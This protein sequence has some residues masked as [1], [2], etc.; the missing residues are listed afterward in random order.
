MGCGLTKQSKN[1]SKAN[2]KVL[3]ALVLNPGLF[4]SKFRGKL[5][6]NYTEIRKLGSGAFAEVKLCKYL[7]TNK[8][9]AVKVI[10]KAGLHQQQID[11]DFMLKEISVLTSLD[12]PNI[13]KCYE[14]FED[15]WRFY[16]AM[17]YCAGGELFAK[18]VQM[19]K[20]NEMQAAEIMHQLLS[21]ICYC[22]E[23]LVIHR[24]LKP[25][26]ILLDEKNG[27]LR[28]KVADFGS[29]CFLD[30]NK[31]LSGCFGSAYYV[32]PE[33]LQ[34]EYN[35][36]CDIW[37]CG[38]IL[39]ILLTGKPPYPGN[40]SKL[41]LNLIRTNPLKVTSE[42]VPGVSAEALDL[43]Q[44]MLAIHPKGR[45]SAKDAVNHP[46]ISEN[47]ASRPV[48]LSGT[49]STLE[50][51]NSSSKLKDAVHI[52]L[53]THVLSYEE[54][55]I[56]TQTFQIIDSNSDGKISRDELLSKYLETME[57][58]KAKDTVEHIMKEIDTNMSGDIDYTEF[59]SA[60]MD[61]NK[62]LSKENLEDAFKLFDRDHSGTISAEELMD[63]LGQNA[64]LPKEI[65]NEV[66]READQNGDGVIDLR[67]FVNLMTN[68]FN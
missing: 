2:N 34:D 53:A 29:S 12:H 1:N 30:A 8:E 24:D 20:F 31:R 42:K 17:E 68:K 43:L 22:H 45:I 62:C 58:S 6:A 37:S 57:E 11:S 55:K 18:I 49:L 63:V 32:A 65:W 61:Y 7:P 48:D 64:D 38:V 40:D 14:I 9:R 25:E 4:L 56:L 46:W 15:S 16:V 66:L 28:I 52:F 10:H 19:K 54:S 35:E 41:I 59:L 26:N 21:A 3:D 13:L 44:K 60:C 33:V 47:R 67:E 27:D 36:K 5:S 39:Y 50:Q 23:K 51:F